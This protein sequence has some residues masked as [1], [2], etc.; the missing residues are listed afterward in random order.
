MAP[1]LFQDDFIHAT[2]DIEKARK[3]ND[4]INKMIKERGLNLNKKKTVILNIGSKKQKQKLSK[5]LKENPVLVGETE[6]KEV[7]EDKWLGQYLSSKGLADSVLKTIEAKEPKIKAAGLEIAAII[8]DWR[9][10]VVGGIDSALLMWEACCI[11]SLLTGAGTWVNITPAA[12]QRLEALQH[13]FLRLVLRVGPGCPVASLRWETGVL[14]MKL[15]VWVEKVMLVRHLRSLE[16]GSLA[17][18]VLEEQ[19]E[20]GWPGLAKETATICEEL[21]IEDCNT[22][23]IWQMSNKNYR[24]MLIETCKLKD[25]MCLRKLAEGKSKC[26]KIME[27][28]YGKKPYLSLQV[29]SKVRQVFYTRVR[30]Q[31]FAG[32][33]PSD[34]RFSKSNHLCLCAVEKEDETHLLAGNCPIY[35]DLRKK[36][37]NLESDLDLLAFFSAVLARRERL[38]EEE[39]RPLAAGGELPIV[40]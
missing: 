2:T 5:Q 12:E 34:K 7:E 4:K 9:S 15:R 40:C 10:Q 30:M 28:E 29:L 26:D 38:E 35:G 20:K 19:Q 3:T 17:R 27:E 13:W 32:N 21:G 6:T 39:R 33:F 11:P 37:S 23:N 18:S 1:L 14:S 22:S 24:K 31:P 16:E 8:Q 25:E 36:H